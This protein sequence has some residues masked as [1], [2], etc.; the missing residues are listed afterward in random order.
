MGCFGE[1]KECPDDCDACECCLEVKDYA[2]G[3]E[4]YDYSSDWFPI[5]GKGW[6]GELVGLLKGPN[7]GPIRV[8]ERNQPMAVA[9]SVGRYISPIH[10][11]PIVR[12]EVPSKAV[13]IRKMKYDTKFGESAVPREQPQNN[14]AV[15]KQIY[16]VS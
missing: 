12:K 11:A 5:S 3:F 4:S 9:L 6:K 1:E 14:T 15:I 13:R 8:P 2:P 7:A 10:E 16:N